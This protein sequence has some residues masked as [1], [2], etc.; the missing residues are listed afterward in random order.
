MVNSIYVDEAPRGSVLFFRSLLLLAEILG[1]ASYG[2]AAKVD[3]E[4]TFT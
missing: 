2:V 4:E 1:N 3:H